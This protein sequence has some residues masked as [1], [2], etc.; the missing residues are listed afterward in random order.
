MQLASLKK[1]IEEDQRTYVQWQEE[2]LSLATIA[3]DLVQQHRAIIDQDIGSLLTE[4]KVNS[5]IVRLPLHLLQDTFFSACWNAA[6]H[7]LPS[8][9][10]SQYVHT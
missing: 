10:A 4:L 3:V 7:F 2:K 9:G 8:D 1:S 5:C 6:L